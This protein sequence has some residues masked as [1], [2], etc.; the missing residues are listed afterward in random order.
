[1]FGG[2]KEFHECLVG[3]YLM[4]S[5]IEF[6]ETIRSG[7][8]FSAPPNGFPPSIPPMFLQSDIHIASMHKL[9]EDRSALLRHSVKSGVTVAKQVEMW[10]KWISTSFIWLNTINN[11][12]FQC[13]PSNEVNHFIKD[14]HR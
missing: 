3:H 4:L 5:W 10:P 13:M 6:L 7:R 1:V 11:S 8:Q 14:L 9:F 2:A 12:P